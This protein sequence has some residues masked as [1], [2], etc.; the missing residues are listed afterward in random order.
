MRQ[1]SGCSFSRCKC[2]G[3][4]T[5][6]NNN[7]PGDERRACSLGHACRRRDSPSARGIRAVSRDGFCWRLEPL[8]VGPIDTSVLV[9]DRETGR[10]I[11]DADGKSRIPAYCQC[12]SSSLCR[13]LY[14]V[15]QKTSYSRPLLLTYRPLDG[16]PSKSSCVEVRTRWSWPRNFSL[17]RPLLAWPPFGHSLSFRLSP[18]AYS[19]FIRRSGAQD[20]FEKTGFPLPTRL[21]P[22]AVTFGA[23]VVSDTLSLVVFA[24]CVSTLSERFFRTCVGCA[25]HGDSDL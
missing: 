13:A 12:E 14:M 9:Q 19:P 4:F 11:L 22:I 15:R 20:C 23:T 17:C 21:E 24:V 2:E 7:N 3:W 5:G 18:S 25:T 6:E 10:V 1:V 16:G 8:Q